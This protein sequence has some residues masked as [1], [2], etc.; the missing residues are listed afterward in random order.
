LYGGVMSSAA[1]YRMKARECFELARQAQ[2]EKAAET[3]RRQGHEYADLATVMDAEGGK[4]VEPQ[5]K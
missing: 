2:T 5:P 1:M 4:G 3:L